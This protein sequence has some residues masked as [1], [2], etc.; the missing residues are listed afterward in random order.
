MSHEKFK[1]T[2]KRMHE[3]GWKNHYFKP[4]YLFMIGHCCGVSTYPQLYDGIYQ[5]FQ[6][7]PRP[8]HN[9]V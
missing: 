3:T 4:A 8:Y 2:T 6:N 9:L 1:K 7:L 5:I